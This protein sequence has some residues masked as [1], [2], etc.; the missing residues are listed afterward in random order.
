MKPPLAVRGSWEAR[1]TAQILLTKSKVKLI[2][3]KTE[4]VNR[5][6]YRKHN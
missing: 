5:I 1:S 4:G 6:V 2:E 3:S